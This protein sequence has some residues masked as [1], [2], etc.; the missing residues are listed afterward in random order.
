MTQAG[1]MIDFNFCKLLFNN[2][3]RRP[4]VHTDNHTGHCANTI[5]TLGKE[6]H[7][8]QPITREARQAKVQLAAFPQ[9]GIITQGKTCHVKDKE[10]VT[11]APRCRQVVM[12]KVEF[13]KE[14]RPATNVSIKSTRKKKKE[15]LNQKL[16]PCKLDSFEVTSMDVTGPYLVTPRG[17]KY[18]LTFIDHFTKYVEAYPLKD[19]T[20]ESCA[21]IYATQI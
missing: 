9:C 20:A 13:E 21:R 18:L 16:L 2:N 19:Q 15:A 3:G 4:R 17:N 14:Q 12:G 11:H 8:P 7:S 1:A 6:G 5:F 10:N